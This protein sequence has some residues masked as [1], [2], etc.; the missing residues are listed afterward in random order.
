MVSWRPWTGTDAGWDELVASLPDANPFQS[1]AWAAHKADFGWQPVRLHAEGAAVQFLRKKAPGAALLW[2]RGG[3]V[4]GPSRWEG[5]RP[6]ALRSAGAALA[7]ARVGSYR[8]ALDGELAAVERQG[9]RRPARALAGD[10][11][12]LADLSVTE[13]ELEAALSPNWAHNLRRGLK[14]ASPRLWERPDTG[15]IAAVYRSMEAYKGLQE[16]QGE[17]ALRSMLERFGDALIVAR[18]GEGTAEAV[19][20]CLVLGTG[21]WDLWAA[22]GPAARKSYASYALLWTLWLEC[23]RRGVKRYELGGADAEKAKG[24]YDFKKGTGAAP[25]TYLGEWDAA[26]PAA[27]RRLAGTL[28]ARKAGA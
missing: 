22:A 11:S 26:R 17:A 21:A 12:F 24:V 18:A 10:G 5:L 14:R 16:Q 25:V 9:W 3:P 20:A 2:A 13:A 8:T 23:R 28:A 4:G 19:R 7:Y 15:E 1:S 27:L 6:E